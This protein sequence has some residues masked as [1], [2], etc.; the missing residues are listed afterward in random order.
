MESILDESFLRKL[1]SIR[2]AALKGGQ[3]VAS[4][5]HRSYKAGSSQE[6]MDYRRYHPGDDIRYVDWTVFGRTDRLFIKLFHAEKEQTLYILLDVSRSMGSGPGSK[7]EYA[8]KTAAALSYMGLASQ[9]QVWVT[10]FSEDLDIARESEKGKHLYLSVQEYISSLGSEGMTDFNGALER[11]AASGNT[12]GTVVVI[13]DL[14]D[15]GG[16]KDGFR[17]LLHSRHKPTLIQILDPEEIRPRFKGH[18]SLED[19]ESG[20]IRHFLVNKIRLK[21]YEHR[22]KEFLLDIGQFCRQR[23]IDYHLAD[24]G[25]AFEDFFLGYLQSEHLTGKSG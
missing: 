18:V 17:A 23:G 25:I 3:G 6:F 12:P 22:L 24:T 9:D 2:A 7:A 19:V 14:L 20:K 10:S 21:R 5:I 11:F 15:P 1:E 8:K 16:Y 13:S 4:G